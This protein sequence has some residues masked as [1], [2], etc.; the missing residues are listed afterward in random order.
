MFS[1]RAGKSHCSMSVAVSSR[2]EDTF[3]WYLG[4]PCVCGDQ[5]QV[6][7]LQLFQITLGEGGGFPA[8]SHL[9]DPG[10]QRGG[11]CA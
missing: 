7:K 10:L 6:A 4:I 3:T 1:S 2:G 5:R 8:A 11:S 9:E